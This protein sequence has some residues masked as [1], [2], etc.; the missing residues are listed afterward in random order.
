MNKKLFL[1][2]TL[3]VMSVFSNNALANN[4]YFDASCMV[5]GGV[6]YKEVVLDR[7]FTDG[8]AQNRGLYV[9]G[10]QGGIWQLKNIFDNQLIMDSLVDN[11]KTAVIL[12]NA[13]NIC[14]DPSTRPNTIWSLELMQ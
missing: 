12:G 5:A 4:D 6:S 1:I 13:V 10:A 8:T 14:A 2:P 11:S 3:A 9:E 7:I